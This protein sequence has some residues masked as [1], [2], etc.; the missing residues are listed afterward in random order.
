M[1]EIL[2]ESSKEKSSEDREIS[3]SNL[4][5]ASSVCTDLSIIEPIR[6]KLLSFNPRDFE[7][8]IHDLLLHSGFINIEVTKF[9]QDGGIDLNARPNE[10]LWP[11]RHMLLQFQAKKWLHTVGRKEVAEFRGSMQPHAIGCIITTSHFSKAAIRES[12]EPGKVPISVIDGHL[13]ASIIYSNN[14]I[15]IIN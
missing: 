5:E 4:K 13:L 1:K 7:F 9:S 12:S 10:S 15:S 14:N 6:R 2:D 11:L 8:F 3:S